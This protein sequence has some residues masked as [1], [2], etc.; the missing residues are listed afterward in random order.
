MITDTLNS[1]HTTILKVFSLL[2][3]SFEKSDAASTYIPVLDDLRA[4]YFM[5]ISKREM[6]AKNSATISVFHGTLC[7]TIDGIIDIVKKSATYL[8]ERDVSQIKKYMDAMLDQ[9]IGDIVKLNSDAESALYGTYNTC[10]QCPIEFAC[11]CNE[12]ANIIDQS[13]LATKNSDPHR[14][15]K[16]WADRIQGKEK[17]SISEN[18]L[19]KI[20]RII[21]RDNIA[22]AELSMMTMRRILSETKL[23]KLNKHVSY[24]IAHFGGIPAPVFS[25]EEDK[26]VAERFSIAK[27][28]YNKIQQGKSDRVY[29]PFLFYQIYAEMF[30]DNPDKLRILNYIYMQS[31]DTAIK[32]GEIYKK[33]CI[34]IGPERAALHG[35]V[36]RPTRSK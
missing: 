28:F 5:N 3:A 21:N 2:R 25:R 29:F 20:K 17:V 36:Y 30:K 32:N 22:P 8:D 4:D 16:A 24:L 9:N 34:M 23:T 26:I 19:T 35:L 10:G 6:D 12:Y 14:H 33:I 31:E 7:A 1:N 18:D 11:V 27:E 15:H 13:R